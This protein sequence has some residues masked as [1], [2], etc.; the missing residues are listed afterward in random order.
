M[1]R[2]R[3]LLSL[4]VLVT[5][6][7]QNASAQ[8]APAQGPSVPDASA[9]NTSTQG[10]GRK[11][12]MFGITVNHMSINPTTA[13]G[14]LVGARSY[15]MQFDG[16]VTFAKFL[17]AGVDFGP[18]FLS[19]R[20]TFT[21]NTTG[22]E[23]KSTAMLVYFSAMAGTRTPPLRLVPGLP[24]T[25]LGVYGGTSATKGERSIDNCLDCL[26]QDIKVP[27]GSFVQPT[28]VFGEGAARFR[29]SDRLY[30]G[31][32]G[33]KSVISLGMELGGR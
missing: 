11:P 18:Q 3:P 33:M 31:G 25:S 29:V 19:D 17:F 16:G 7:V 30:M 26:S 1:R 27:G 28:L 20:A 8:N 22:G 10:A 12:F 2:T 14:Q 13:A 9:K 6:V 5:A 21:Q 24:A 4:L 23:K 15:G 32:E